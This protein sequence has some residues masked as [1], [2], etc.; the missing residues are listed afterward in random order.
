MRI[1]IT[2][3]GIYDGEGKEIPIGTEFDVEDPETNEDGSEVSAHP[4]AGRFE[5][6]SGDGKA[7][8]TAKT[9]KADGKGKGKD[10]QPPAEFVAP[11]GPFTAKEKSPG[12]WAIF[13]GSDQPVGK[14]VRKNDLEGF[15]GLSD[16]DKTAF[17]TEHAKA[18]F[19][20]ENKA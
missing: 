7:K 16:D 11:T 5:A 9:P 8:P 13:D 15:D 12:W 1:K 2:A 18:A 17:A 3:G 20:A 19:E 6:I 14:A 10:E 4:W